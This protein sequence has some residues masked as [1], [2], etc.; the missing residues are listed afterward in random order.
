MRTKSYYGD[1]YFM[2]FVDDFSKMMWTLFLREKSK[3]FHMFKIYKAR[4]EKET[5]KSLK[6]LRSDRGGEYTS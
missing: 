2:L 6:C 5:G 3:A 1:M 4:A